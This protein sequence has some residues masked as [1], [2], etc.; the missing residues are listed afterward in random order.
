[1]SAT[2]KFTKAE[3]AARVLT[4]SLSI[5][6]AIALAQYHSR[7]AKSSAKRYGQAALK[8]SAM[9]AMPQ[10]HQHDALF[11]AAQANMAAHGARCTEI[12]NLA[13]EAVKS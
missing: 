8:L 9:S 3:P 2:A 11:E 13:K 12:I 4:L 1:M 7:E 5:A 10:R 6:E